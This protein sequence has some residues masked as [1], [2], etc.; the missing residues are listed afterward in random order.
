MVVAGQ[1]GVRTIAVQD[2]TSLEVSTGSRTQV[3]QDGLIGLGA[4]VTV[5]FALGA[6]TYE[7]PDFFVSSATE[8]GAL[9]GAV[10]GVVGMVAGGVVG[11]LHR[12]DRSEA[13]RMPMRASI[14]PSGPAGVKVSFSRVF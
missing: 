4:G 13:A 5:G 6:L 7:D 14:G 9:V 11:A 10:F 8:A 1:S 3:L 2:I 12:T